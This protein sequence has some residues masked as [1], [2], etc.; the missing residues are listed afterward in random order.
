MKRMERT[1]EMKVNARIVEELSNGQ[2]E[3][4]IK[5]IEII[6]EER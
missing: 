3:D 1:V 4:V 2:P 6:I 5:I